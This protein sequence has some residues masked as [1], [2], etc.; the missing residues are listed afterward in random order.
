MHELLTLSLSGLA[1]VVL[2][3]FFFGGLWW[4]VRKGAASRRPGRWFF[5]S[6]LLRMGIAVS[7][8]YLIG[9]DDW[10]RLLICLLGFV[11]ARFIVTALAGP[12]LEHTVAPAREAGH[13][14]DA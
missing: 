10:R 14:P 4:T 11:I 6:L 3:G 2:G 9:A 13:A 5:G 7:G 12:P 8:F 1:G